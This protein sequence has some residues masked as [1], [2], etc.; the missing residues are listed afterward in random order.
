[1]PALILRLAIKRETQIVKSSVKSAE[2]DRKYLQDNNL[3]YTKA[4]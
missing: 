1:M 4:V 3:S 2:S